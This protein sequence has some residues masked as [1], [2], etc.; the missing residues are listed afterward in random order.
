LVVPVCALAAADGGYFAESW[1]WAT[2]AYLWLAALALIFRRRLRLARLDLVLL[3]SVSTLAVW[4]L[5]S[6]AWSSSPANAPVE[7][8]RALVYVAAVAAVL[9]LVEPRSVRS[10]MSALTAG[11]TL[12]CA[13]GLVD[14][15][16][17]ERPQGLDTLG[18]GRL[19]EPLGYWNA[20]GLFAAMG[21]VLALALAAEARATVGRAAAAAAPVVLLPTLYYTFGRAA[22]L[23]LLLGL[24][25]AVS[26]ARRRRQLVAAATVLAPPAVIAVWL[27]SRLDALTATTLARMAESAREARVLAI[28]LA[29]L[30]LV[31]AIAGARLLPRACEKAGSIR[32]PQPRPA[33]LLAIAGAAVA[34]AIAVADPIRLVERGYESFSGPPSPV[35]SD[36]RARVF[37]LTG[38]ARADA[39]KIAWQDYREHPVL[40][41]GAGT[42]EHYW[43]EHRPSVTYF[44]DAHSLYLETLA[45]LGPLGLALVAGT[46]AAMVG[47]AVRVRGDP[48]AAGA[49]GAVVAFLVHAGV[50]W[51][52]EMP[53]VTCSALACGAAL[54]VLARGEQASTAPWQPRAGGVALT[55]ALGAVAVVG[56]VGNGAIAA[57]ISELRSGDY[58]SAEEEARRASRWAP[59]S[60]EPWRVLGEVRLRRGQGERARAALREATERD[61]RNWVLWAELASASQGVARRDARA[62]A[63]A[64]NPS[65]WTPSQLHPLGRAL[66]GLDH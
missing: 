8:Q 17:S 42:F 19:A 10:L 47:A 64:L 49:F 38:S 53:A 5:F 61:P 15:I 18:E 39:W 54:V 57:S 1:G 6:A 36:L 45:E 58:A 48:L 25:G 50:D 55:V 62:R 33:A 44:R 11:I 4:I 41:S 40:G 22:W 30:A 46:V 13:W 23:A 3:G 51:D 65:W 35:R 29:G 60:A 9:L 34:G 26:F 2:L 7:A 14:H 43:V 63:H 32:L 20:V 52:W 28:G 31:A 12:V 16:F 21:T 59:W 66:Q 37:T 56:L 24:T 27:S